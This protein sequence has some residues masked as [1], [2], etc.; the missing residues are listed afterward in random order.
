MSTRQCVRQ[1]QL[2]NRIPGEQLAMLQ[3][4]QYLEPL[5][6]P[7]SGGGLT[8]PN[9]FVMA[10][11]TR[12]FSPEGVPDARVAAYYKRR[13]AGGTGLIITEGTWIE[14]EAAGND[15]RC[16]RFFGDDALAGW[17][18]TV[19]AIHEAGGKVIPQLW[20]VGG[21]RKEAQ[22][23]NAGVSPISPSG[24]KG[25]D[26]PVGK[27]MTQRDIDRA[28]EA[29]AKGAMTA[30]QLGFD[31]VELHAAH[32]YLID[33]FFWQGTNRRNDRYGGDLRQRTTFA[34]EIVRECRR[35]VGSGYPIVLR[36]SQWKL[37]DYNARIVN[38]AQEL[39]AFLAPLSNAGVDVFH[40]STRRYWDAAFEGHSRTLAGWTK[41][42]SGKPTIA[43]G[44]VGLA[45]PFLDSGGIQG[46]VPTTLERLAELYNAGE[47][48]LVALGRML[49][50]NPD[51]VR[52]IQHE[53]LTT[54]PSFSSDMVRSQ[55]RSGGPDELH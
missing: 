42:I 31:G 38:S 19:D 7:F 35:R 54:M 51:Y 50:V 14:H 53:P 22:Q 11:M 5:F 39:E 6:A 1:G 8:L 47:F 55:F 44:S 18:L 40:V 52:R 13:A 26:L 30:Q 21:Q 24:Y 25:P 32:G 15:G 20:H 43:V 3:A 33:Q 49:V 17:K 16:P 45:Q 4:N 12:F 9:R 34:A 41:Y 28:I 23:P 10:P 36:F 2:G 46:S 27:P 37:P 29:Y 48:D